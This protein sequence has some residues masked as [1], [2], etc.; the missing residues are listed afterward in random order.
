MPVQHPTDGVEHRVHREAERVHLGDPLLDQ[1]EVGEGTLELVA[2]LDPL[3]RLLSG[4][5][6]GARDARRERAPAVVETGQRDLETLPLTVEQVLL[7][8]A[9]VLEADARLPRPTDSRL[10]AVLLE[11]AD[12]L[13]VRRHDERRDALLDAARLRVGD[14]LVGHHGEKARD[15]ARG[16]PLLL[17]VEDVDLLLLIPL[18]VRLLARRVGA[19]LRLAQA[20]ARQLL[21]SDHRQE[22]VLLVVGSEEHQRLA[23]DRLVGGHHDGGGPASA[24]DGLQHTVVARDA[25]AEAAERLRDRHPHHTHVEQP[26]HDPLGDHLLLVDHDAGMLI[27]EV[28]LELNEQRVGLGRLLDGSLRIGK[29]QLLTDPAPE[30]VLDEAHLLGLRAEHRLGFL[31]H[32]LVAGGDALH[33]REYGHGERWERWDRVPD[34]PATRGACSGGQIGP[35]ALFCPGM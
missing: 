6:G 5:L 4:L 1:F 3:R 21:A 34:K 32:L 16:D 28:V 14:L 23:A 13:H 2:R 19:H 15:G 17:A 29:H 20:E 26:L 10:G 25:E 31:D 7:R 33:F 22:A 35:E 8:H 18:A 12:A 11:E 30:E 9:D 27:F 24:A